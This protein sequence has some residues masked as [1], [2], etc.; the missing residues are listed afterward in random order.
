MEERH[1]SDKTIHEM[2]CNDDKTVRFFRSCI[3]RGKLHNVQE[4]K[5]DRRVAINSCVP[6]EMERRG[7]YDRRR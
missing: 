1:L 4:R 6:P 5:K 2:Q 7:G 3:R